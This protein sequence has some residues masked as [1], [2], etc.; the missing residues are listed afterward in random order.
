MIVLRAQDLAERHHGK[1]IDKDTFQQYF[2]LSGLLGGPTTLQDPHALFTLLTPLFPFSLCHSLSL[3]RLFTQFDIKGN[4]LINFDAFVNGLAI[5]SRY[6]PP[7]SK[8]HSC[9]RG[10]PDEKIRFVFNMYDTGRTGT[11][12]KA[13]LTTL[14]NHS[15]PPPP[16]S[17]SLSPRTILCSI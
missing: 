3:D 12:S 6:I 16:S 8:A 17:L 7:A 9:L 15:T 4:G 2:P 11:V 13:D 5:C 10:T 1:G 14:L